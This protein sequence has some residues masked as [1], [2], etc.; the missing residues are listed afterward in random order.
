M[1]K[2]PGNVVKPPTC[3]VELTELELN[4]RV[5]L[6]DTALVAETVSTEVGFCDKPVP[7]T[8]VALRGNERLM[9]E[10]DCKLEEAVIV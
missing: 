1:A 5:D 9:A 4:G 2:S 3:D 7:G 8:E 6:E 10:S